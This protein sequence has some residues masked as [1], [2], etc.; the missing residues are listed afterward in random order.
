MRVLM[1]RLVARKLLRV[2]TLRNYWVITAIISSTTGWRRMRLP[3]ILILILL[4][5]GTK[6]EVIIILT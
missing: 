2:M 1:V 4:V 6:I 5:H 3:C